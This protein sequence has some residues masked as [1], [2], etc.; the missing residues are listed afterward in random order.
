MLIKS[1]HMQSR[2]QT[3]VG[4]FK[5]ILQV[6]PDPNLI[7]FINAGCFIKFVPYVIQFINV[8]ERSHFDQFSV[9]KTFSLNYLY[10]GHI[11]G[12]VHQKGYLFIFLLLMVLVD[13][14]IGWL[15]GWIL[16]QTLGYFISK[17]SLFY[18]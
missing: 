18:S 3:F 17:V 5:I 6:R 4:R 11:K 14:V 8:L 12:S 10:S 16:R 7:H 2:E 15:D 9:F 13:W 1:K